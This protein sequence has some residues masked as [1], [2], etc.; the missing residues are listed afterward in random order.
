MS[1]PSVEKNEK[2]LCLGV[3]THLYKQLGHSQLPNSYLEVAGIEEGLGK[4]RTLTLLG[5]VR[6]KFDVPGTDGKTHNQTTV[7][8]A[9]GH[10]DNANKLVAGSSHFCVY[11][12]NAQIN[13]KSHQA[14]VLEPLDAALERAG[15]S[16]AE[17]IE[18]LVAKQMDYDLPYSGTIK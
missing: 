9:S 2:V 10:I 8:L 3:P 14:F 5:L 4:N 1:T 15:M 17:F 12:Y 18:A 16:R 11:R 13:P 7:N 6:N